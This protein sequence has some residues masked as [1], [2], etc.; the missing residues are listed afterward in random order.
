MVAV[1]VT[2]PPSRWHGPRGSPTTCCPPSPCRC[3]ILVV[4]VVLVVV[5]ARGP[6]SASVLALALLAV[7]VV[8]QASAFAHT[9]LP[10]SRVQDFYPVTPT[11]TYLSANL[12]GDRYGAA[13]NTM[14]APTSDYYELRTPVGH[15]FTDQRWKDVVYAADPRAQLTVTY[16]T[17]SPE[18][19]HRA[20]RDLAGSRPA[21]RALLGGEPGSSIG[22]RE[23]MSGGREHIQLDERDA[24]TCTVPGGPLRGVQV[25]VAEAMPAV[26]D[27]RRPMLHAAVTSGGVERQG[28]ILIDSDLDRAGS[29]SPSRA[30]TCPPARPRASESG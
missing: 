7:L 14:F 23:P 19:A 5:A 30:R 10:G 4:G 13:G 25:Q 24:G 28:A 6:R 18:P 16:S 8:A 17:F 2:A 12:H 15:E 27:G 9:L 26:T 29:S 22:V 20:D 11:H 1:L 3:C 21:R